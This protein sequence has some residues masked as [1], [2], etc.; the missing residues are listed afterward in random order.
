MLH[1]SKVTAGERGTDWDTFCGELGKALKPGQI[2]RHNQAG[3]LPTLKDR[4]TIDPFRMSQLTDAAGHA[5]GFTY[6]HHPLSDLNV[7]TIRETTA[8]GLTVNA[9]CETEQQADAA[10]A[11]GLLAVITDDREE[12]SWRTPDGNRVM[13]CPAQLRK[14]MDCDK[15]RLCQDRRPDVIVRFIPHGGG[16][17][18]AAEAVAKA[19]A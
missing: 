12:R 17:V 7:Q 9:S 18:K 3:D 2:W 19:Q 11:D 5:A 4:V 14:D 16:K 8:N 10:I 15:C 6:T 1:W 13:T